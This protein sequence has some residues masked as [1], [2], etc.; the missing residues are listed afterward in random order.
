VAGAGDRPGALAR[1]RD[2]PAPRCLGQP[3]HDPEAD[4]ALVDAVSAGLAGHPFARVEMR[5]E[6][7]NDPAFAEAA[8][9]RLLELLDPPTAPR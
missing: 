3:F 5:D 4:R 2:A 9:G 7:I 1:G 6:H 8:A